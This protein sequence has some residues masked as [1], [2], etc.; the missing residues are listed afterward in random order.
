MKEHRNTMRILNRIA[1]AYVEKLDLDN[2]DLIMLND[3][4]IT[5]GCIPADLHYKIKQFHTKPK[6]GSN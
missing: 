1:D 6:L 4:E 3:C 2:V 5:K